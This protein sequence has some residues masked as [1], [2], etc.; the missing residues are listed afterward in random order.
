MSDK[1]HMLLW[2]DTE[3]TGIDPKDGRL[4]EVGMRVTDLKASSIQEQF[5]MAIRYDPDNETPIAIGE[6]NLTAIGMHARN[7][8]L[9]Q[10]M[11]QRRARCLDDVRM[12]IGDLIY[13]YRNVIL[14]PAGTNVDFDLEWIDEKMPGALAGVSYRKLDLSSLRITDMARGRDPY[15]YG[16]DTIHRTADCLQR[17]IDEYR[18]WLDDGE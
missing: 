3:T 5:D 11:D 1:P 8:L 2:I 14:H 10:C 16:H 4:L 17:D 13:R 15:A 7:G 9:A 6:R 18:A 12:R